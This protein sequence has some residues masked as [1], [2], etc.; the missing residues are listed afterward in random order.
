M[1]DL[2]PAI[3]SGEI[4]QHCVAAVVNYYRVPPNLI[5]GILGQEGGRV[6]TASPNSNGSVDYGPAQINSAWLK[7]VQPYGVTAHKL[8]WDPCMNLWV[9]GWI[10][11]RCLNKFPSSEWMAIGCYHVG[12][13]PRKE[14]HYTRMQAYAQKIRAK[15]IQYAPAFQRW[16]TTGK[17]AGQVASTP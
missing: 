12:E 6:G 9:S 13:N 14:S 2:P 11:R 8:R 10:M 5:V 16:L 7:T 3:A 15:S 17:T 1:F 4:P